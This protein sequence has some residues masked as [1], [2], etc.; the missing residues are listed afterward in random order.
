MPA[1][2][3]ARIVAALNRV[4]LSA[5]AR[6]VAVEGLLPSAP[7]PAKPAAAAPAKPVVKKK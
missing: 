1:S 4:G 2:D 7:A 6:A 5:D 3:R